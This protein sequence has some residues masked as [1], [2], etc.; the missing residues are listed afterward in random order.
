M[1][2]NCL[3]AVR[4][5]LNCTDD[6]LRLVLG[7]VRD[8]QLLILHIIFIKVSKLEERFTH[9]TDIN[10]LLKSLDGVFEHR[11]NRLHDAKTAFHII[12]L[13][14]HSLDGLHLACDFDKWLTIVESLQNSGSKGLLDVLDGSCLGNGGIGITSGLAGEGGVEVGLEGDEEVIFVHGLELVGGDNGDKSGG[15]FHF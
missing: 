12:D 9:A 13:R 5:L 11:L 3:A 14:L 2:S 10:D 8:N 4:S 7:E 6:F 1:G 15:E